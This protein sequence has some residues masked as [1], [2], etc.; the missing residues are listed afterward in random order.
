VLVMWKIQENFGHN[1][2]ERG[3]VVLQMLLFKAYGERHADC[4]MP[5]ISFVHMNTGIRVQLCCCRRVGLL[6]SWTMS[7]AFSLSGYR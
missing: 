7:A 2:L 1:T 3:L 5:V 6:C 4:Q